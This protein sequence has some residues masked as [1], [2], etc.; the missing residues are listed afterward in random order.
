MD[1]VIQKS[2][3]PGDNIYIRNCYDLFTLPD[4]D[5]DSDSDLDC[6]P[7]VLCCTFHT[8]FL[9]NNYRNVMGVEI[10]ICE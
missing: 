8:A 10:Q 3:N 4:S 9:S 2:G 1:F 5:T 7:Y 6:K